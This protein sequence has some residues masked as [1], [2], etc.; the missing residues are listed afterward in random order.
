MARL[1]LSW[2]P[3]HKPQTARMLLSPE[4]EFRDADMSKN[5]GR[6]EER[7]WLSKMFLGPPRNQVELNIRQTGWFPDQQGRSHGCSRFFFLCPKP[8]K[9]MPHSV[10]FVNSKMYHG[11]LICHG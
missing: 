2:R 9:S 1:Q 5:L 11:S 3:F 8:I 6:L 4:Q 10:K 7:W